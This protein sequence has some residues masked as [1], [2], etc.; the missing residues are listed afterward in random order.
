MVRNPSCASPT[1]TW[2][3]FYLFFLRILGTKWCG[4]GDISDSYNDLGTEREADMCC[5]DH[6][7]CPDFI[8]GGETKYDL[9]NDGFYTSL[10]VPVGRQKPK[11]GAKIL[12]W[13][14]HLCLRKCSSTIICPA[15]L[16]SL[17]E[18][19]R[20]GRNRPWTPLPL[21]LMHDF[22]CTICRSSCKCD[23]QFL[24]CL[25]TAN[26]MTATEVGIIYSNLPQAKCFKE[27]YPVTG[28]KKRGGY[29]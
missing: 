21:L 1:R 4:P 20:R 3:V 16:I 19:S 24:K 7:K 17:N 2:P 26:T 14:P 8:H 15:Q 27:D 22:L 13:V 25:R 18:N 6:D 23:S 28:C 9:T 10:P 12:H 11:L 5:R 29:V